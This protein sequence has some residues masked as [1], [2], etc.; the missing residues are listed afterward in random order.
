MK[1]IAAQI[2]ILTRQRSSRRNLKA[3]AKFL[4]VLIGMIMTYTVIFHLIM[5]Y[6]VRMNF[7]GQEHHSWLSGLYWTLVTMSTL[8]FGDITFQSDLGRAFTIIVILSGTLFLLVLL[9]FTFIQ[10]FYAPWVESQAQASTPQDLPESERDHVLLTQIDPVTEAL[11]KKLEQFGHRYA[12]IVEE[13]DEARRLHDQNYRVMR[14]DLDDP[15]TYES[16]RLSQASMLVSTLS[17]AADTTVCITARGVSETTPIVTTVEDPVSTQIH[18]MA[19]ASNTIRLPEIMGQAL[20]RCSSGGDAITHTVATFGT[21]RLAEANA[22]KT[23]LVGKT[24]R[25][26]RLGDLGVSVAGLWER[27][28]FKPARP[29]SV[30]GPNTVMMV[31]GSEEQLLNYDEHFAIYAVSGEPVILIGSGRIGKATAEAL[32]ERGVQYRVIE[33]NPNRVINPD[34]TI[35]G[36]AADPEILKQAGIATTPTVI[37]TTNDDDTNLYL[38]LLCRQSNP[39]VEIIARCTLDKHVKAL[40]KAGAD[41]VQSYASIGASSIFNLLQKSR[42]VTVTQ[43]LDVFRVNVPTEVIGKTIIE[44]GIREKT[45]CTIIGY[46]KDDSLE[47]NPRPDT[48]LEKGR[49]MLMIGDWEARNSYFKAYPAS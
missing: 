48:V 5:E 11:I 30:V 28:E 23:P 12:L 17:D 4:A 20:A 31:V 39:D 34:I 6:E 3:L 21:L 16:A 44:C 33:Q 27:G 32:E 43:G 42:V 24:L 14:G 29:D 40:H 18:E 36:N 8:G 7:E 26:N 41:F 13:I 25:E 37:I 19:G 1:S 46:H 38:T 15:E 2:L 9:P 35:V 49:E 22:S 47:P 10:F 45:G